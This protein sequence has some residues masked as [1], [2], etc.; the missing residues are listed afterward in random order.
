[1]TSRYGASYIFYTDGFLIEGCVGFAVHQ[2]T[3]GGFG[4]KIQSP[5]G[6]FTAALGALFTALR[7]IDE[8]IRP[9][10]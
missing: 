4:Y 10:E 5:A 8:D 9:P 7:H 2:M 6:V 3:V 1:V